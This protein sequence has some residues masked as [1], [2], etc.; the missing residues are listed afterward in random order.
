MC[1]LKEGIGSHFRHLFSFRFTTAKILKKQN[2]PKKKPSRD[3]N[4]NKI[5]NKKMRDKIDIFPQSKIQSTLNAL[6]GGNRN[7]FQTSSKV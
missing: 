1:R 6:K 5:K 2:Q 4:K 7:R 3:G